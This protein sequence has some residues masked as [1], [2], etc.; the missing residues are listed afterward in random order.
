MALDGILLRALTHELSE[1]LT[2]GR[3][4]KVTQPDPEDLIL[5]IH[6]R[7]ETFRLLISVHS[8]HPRVG[9]TDEKRENPVTA[10]LF[11][12][13]LRKHL[14]GGRILSVAQQGLDRILT[15]DVECRDEMGFP[16][17]SR[18]HVELMGK[19]SNLIFYNTATGR[20]IDS[21]HRIGESMSRLRQIHPG[22]LFETLPGQKANLLTVDPLDPARLLEATHSKTLS[23]AL[24]E[25]LEGFS[26]PLCRE[27]LH[28]EGLPDLPR[29]QWSPELMGAL[30]TLLLRFRESLRAHRYEPALI[31][32][33]AGIPVDFSILPLT[34]LL[35]P[36]MTAEPF[37]S[38]SRLIETFYRE[39]SREARLKNK[40]TALRKL[41]GT[42]IARL[43]KK[44]QKLQ[45]D[46]YYAENADESRVLGDLLMANLYQTARGMN[47]I[48]VTDYF[49]PEQ[50]QR[51]IPL[52]V[53]LTPSENAQRYYRKYNKLRTA[54][55]QVQKQMQETREELTYLDAVMTA[56]DT[57][58]EP[59]DIEA[60][61]S[62]LVS[63][64][65][66]RPQRQDRGN[67]KKK[68]S[69]S[70][71]LFTSPTG[72]E[73]LVGRNNLEN[74]RLTLKTASNSDL[75]LHTKDMPGSHVILRT[76][77]QEPDEADI[78]LAARIAAWHSKGRL[79]ENV[80][81]DCTAVRHV[82]KV[83]GARPGMVIY[84]HQRTLFVTP[85]ERELQ[86][87]AAAPR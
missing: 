78:A 6:N 28:R 65:Y 30:Q 2:E 79:S 74:D 38:V 10:P 1:A 60:I 67:R 21:V 81:V 83:P 31:R 16:T 43:E 80:A 54:Q 44:M 34:H 64:G 4:D 82:R 37:D 19:H 69:F 85:D 45:E 55:E 14:A 58:R 13:L 47:E 53:R 42:R 57:S 66:S 87:L 49:Q 32:N 15:L 72:C 76:Q 46:F 50:P 73:I 39:K 36:G 77:G 11:C 25:A 51:T 59:A 48:T 18:L 62:E 56:I 63:Q 5:Q 24:L 22:L 68:D 8:A 27:L 12:M 52:D 20:I 17:A 41:L 7:R 71:L 23:G 35:A 70:P 3:I 9:L 26:Q 75:W 84:D 29:E 40:S 86:A 33:E 61:H